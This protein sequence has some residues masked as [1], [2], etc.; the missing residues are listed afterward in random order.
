MDRRTEWQTEGR[1]DAL[2]GGGIISAYML[3]YVYRLH[4]KE[5]M[6]SLEAWRARIG[7]FSHPCPRVRLKVSTMRLNTMARRLLIWAT[8]LMAICIHCNKQESDGHVSKE[9]NLASSYHGPV[10]NPTESN[11]GGLY[12]E[13][14]GKWDSLSNLLASHTTAL[15]KRLVM[16]GDVEL[17]P[18]P[19]KK[20]VSKETAS[21]V[22]VL[23]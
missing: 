20:R 3:S 9:K 17:N 13:S 23:Y 1:T 4:K 10:F 5:T 8:I 22:S 19:P 12:L 18:G 11:A 21:K 14:R 16:C 15:V 2:L 6:I 7:T